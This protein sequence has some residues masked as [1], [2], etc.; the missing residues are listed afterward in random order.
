LAESHRVTLKLGGSLAELGGGPLLEVGL[1][2]GQTLADVATQSG[3]SPRLVML[4]SV[5]GV[6]RPAEYRPVAGD[7][8]LLIPAVAGG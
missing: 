8:I 3:V 2:E 5:N 7:E 4:Y 6:L 1:E